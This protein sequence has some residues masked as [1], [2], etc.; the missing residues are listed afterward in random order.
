[1]RIAIYSRKSKFTGKGD[2]VEN[3]ITLCKEYADSHF[4]VEN[5]NVY[6]DE[7]F[8]GGNIDRPRFQQLL[9][10]VEKK[11]FDVLICYRLDRISRNVLDF[12]STLELLNKNNIAF[13]SISENFDTSSPIGRAMVYIA[14]VFAQLERETIAE[15]IRDNMHQ[16]AKSGRWLGGNTPTGFE[17]EPVIY[18]DADMK[19]RKMFK[20]SPI[21]EELETVKLLFDKYIEFQSI[22]KLE[23]WCMQNEI[24]SK[25]GKYFHKYAIRH[26]LINPVYAMADSYMYDYFIAQEAHVAADKQEWNGK[27]GVMS[28][29]KNLVKKGQ[30]VKRKD[31]SEWIVSIGKHKG[32]IEGKKWIQVQNTINKNKSKAPRQGTSYAGMLSG[33]LRCGKCNSFMQIKYGQKSR[34]TGERH[35]YYV[36]NRKVISQGDKCDVKNLQGEKTDQEVIDT[37]KVAIKKGILK[38]LDKQKN[39]LKDI[40]QQEK[41]IISDIEENKKAIENLIK[42]LSKTDSDSIT[43]YIFAEI[44][45][46]EKLNVELENKLNKTDTE[47]QAINIDLLKDYY[48]DFAENIDSVPYEKKRILIKNITN[49]IIWDGENLKMDLIKM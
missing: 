15:R 30:S 48:V 9:K 19:E 16:L 24:R 45:K 28:Y 20:L 10:D 33:I 40:R 34:Y 12:S 3:Q 23:T 6:E 43:K 36:C 14:S 2:S 46:L 8:S 38:S 32:I 7:G 29:N 26:I 5:I 11:K 31:M 17:S 44:E 37:L 42:Q 41:K 35:Y 39:S 13:V 18:Y 21:P 1:M 49:K 25:T 47:I 4:D 22:S 27:Y